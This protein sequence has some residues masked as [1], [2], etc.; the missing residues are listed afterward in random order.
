MFRGAFDSTTQD[1]LYRVIVA[2]HANLRE[3]EGV[4]ERLLAGMDL[5]PGTNGS[6]SDSGGAGH[7]RDQPDVRAGTTAL[8]P[9]IS[10]KEGGVGDIATD[11]D[12]GGDRCVA[13]GGELDAITCSTSGEEQGTASEDRL[14][15]DAK[16]RETGCKLR[17][18]LA[19]IRASHR[20]ACQRYATRVE[21]VLEDRSRAAA[22]ASEACRLRDEAI[23]LS[24]EWRGRYEALEKEHTASARSL[25]SR[26]ALAEERATSADVRRQEADDKLNSV[27]RS[28][29]PTL[30]RMV[31]AFTPLDTERLGVSLLET[32]GVDKDQYIHVIARKRMFEASQRSWSRCA[33]LTR[34]KP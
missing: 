28:A 3:I 19:D 33:I 11:R 1:L 15:G 8:P 2:G 5:G 14:A 4:A 27:L 34:S 23:A 20:R 21:G 6:E 16:G 30:T 10:G 9:V 12:S 17:C 24:D 22:E 25:R 7:E 26:L 18:A 29:T 31:S 13:T 32:L